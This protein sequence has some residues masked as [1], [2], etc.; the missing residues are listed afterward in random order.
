MKQ[1]TKT[2][3]FSLLT[4][5]AAI[6]LAQPAGVSAKGGAGGGGNGGGGGG[7]TKPVESRVT[8]Y[9]TFLDYDSELITIGASY[10]GTGSLVITPDTDISLDN[11]NCSLD[12]LAL[13][14]WVE[15]RYVFALDP[16]TGL[17]VRVATKLSATSLPTS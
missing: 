2:K 13:G 15:A 16:A 6:A 5:L 10:Y 12:D 11:V 3:L 8:G 7:S 9:V 17:Y 4:L 14:D 1:Q